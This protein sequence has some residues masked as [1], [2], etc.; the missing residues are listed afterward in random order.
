MFAVSVLRNSELEELANSYKTVAAAKGALTREVRACEEHL[1]DV[2][3]AYE[4]R[5]ENIHGWLLGSK[6]FKHD[7]RTAENNLRTAE[8][9]RANL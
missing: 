2:K 5:G 9:F 4:R 8:K 3:D 6:I 1:K 7:V